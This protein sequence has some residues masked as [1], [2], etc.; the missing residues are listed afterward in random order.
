MRVYTVVSNSNSD[1]HAKLCTHYLVINGTNEKTPQ[2]NS[3]YYYR[4]DHVSQIVRGSWYVKGSFQNFWHHP[5]P[6]F[7]ML[8]EPV[9]IHLIFLLRSDRYCEILK[10]VIF[11]SDVYCDVVFHSA[12][13]FSHYKAVFLFLGL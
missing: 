7:M 2:E 5:C 10:F 11:F 12:Q 8:P 13:P 4:V 9:L 1:C 6:F 3:Y